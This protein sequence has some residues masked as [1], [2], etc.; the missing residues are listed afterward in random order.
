MSAV[1][2]TALL[3]A[4]AGAG[5]L[6][7]LPGPAVLAQEPAPANY[8]ACFVGTTFAHRPPG[9]PF[10]GYQHDVTFSLGYGRNVSPAVSLELDL[11]P[12]LVHGEYA[13]FSLVPGVV[14]VFHRHAYTAMRFI[15][16]VDPEWELALSPGLGF[17]H[18]FRNGVSTT[19]ELNAVSHVGKGSPDFGVS[20]TAGVLIGF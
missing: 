7:A 11:G 9:G 5:L 14:W 16:P 17:I 20:L 3:R 18:T 4:A 12:T 13:G 19:L 6:S 10:E 15:V 2:G 8:G 1:R